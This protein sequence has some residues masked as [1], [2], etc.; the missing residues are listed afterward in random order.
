MLK[1]LTPPLLFFCL[2]FVAWKPKDLQTIFEKHKQ[3]IV[4]PDSAYNLLRSM[5]AYDPAARIS[6]IKAERH[7]YFYD[8]ITLLT[9]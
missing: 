1:R 6:A 8:D 5:L 9:L 2:E 7:A 3:S 4:L